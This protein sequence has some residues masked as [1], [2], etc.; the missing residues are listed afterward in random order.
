[1]KLYIIFSFFSFTKIIPGVR[2]KIVCHTL[3]NSK[4]SDKKVMGEIM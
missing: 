4:N 1:M 2:K 3:C